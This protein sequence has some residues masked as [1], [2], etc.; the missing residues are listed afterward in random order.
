MITVCDLELNGYSLSLDKGRFG[1]VFHGNK[2]I[3]ELTDL[4][5]KIKKVGSACALVHTS[6]YDMKRLKALEY[7]LRLEKK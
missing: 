5:I 7:G 1:K 2:L 4:S 6:D 3:I